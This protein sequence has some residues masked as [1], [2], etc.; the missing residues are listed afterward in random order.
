MGTKPATTKADSVH[1]WSP[2]TDLKG[3]Q[4]L[5][6]DGWGELE[7]AARFPGS[8]GDPGAFIPVG[9]GGR[10]FIPATRLV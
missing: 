5:S 10:L 3:V 7:G 1:C 9:G 8:A 4:N 2:S 6:T